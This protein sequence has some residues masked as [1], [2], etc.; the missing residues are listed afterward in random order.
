MD[1]KE[2]FDSVVVPISSTIDSRILDTLARYVFRRPVAEINDELLVE[3]IKKRC[4][5]LKN[6]YVPDLDK[7]F[8]AKLKMDLKEE[9]TEVRFLNYFALFDQIVEE[10]GLNSILDPG[11]EDA[12]D[13]AERMA[14]RCKYLLANVTPE[15]LRLEIERLAL[16]RP[17]L[18][19]NDMLLFE[20]LVARGREQQHYHSLM[21]ELRMGDKGRRKDTE[22]ETHA[23]SGNKKT[24]RA[25]LK[26]D[27]EPRDGSKKTATTKPTRSNTSNVAKPPPRDGCL[28][29][30]GPHWMSNCDLP[31]DKKKEAQERLSENKKSRVSAKK[32][33]AKKSLAVNG[34][35]TA[36]LNEVLEVSFR[37]DTAA[38]RNVLS[39]HVV[40]ELTELGCDV[41][42]LTME[43]PLEVE[44]ADGRTMVCGERCEV[45]VELVTAA[46]PVHLRKLSCLIIDSDSDE[47]LLGDETLKSLGINVDQQLEQLAARVSTEEDHDDISDDDIASHSSTAM[48]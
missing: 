47:F 21:Q 30:G 44:V 10:H 38:D 40:Q 43:A 18:K 22:K 7:L 24:D 25:P 4:S 23:A 11:R 48:P 31:E 36:I 28:L 33:K 29:C 35:R 17:E 12:P 14:L 39:R 32:A 9:D 16:V 27:Q 46:G 6:G 20:A 5:S 3:T 19:K 1:A 15:M 26:A 8:K 34:E 13:Y 37:A 2:D 42:T 45:N 41:P